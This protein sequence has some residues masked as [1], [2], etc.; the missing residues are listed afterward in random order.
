MPIVLPIPAF[1]DNY[2]W[3]IIK[4]QQAIIVDP[5]DAKPVIQA[6][7]QHQIKLSAILI[8]HWHG[9]HTNGIKELL[10]TYPEAAVIGPQHA[11]IPATQIVQDNQSLTVAGINF[12]VLAVPGHTLEHVAYYQAEQEWLF[13]GDTL[14]AA[15]CGR[16]FEGSNEQMLTSLQRLAALPES[17]KIFCAHEYTLSN[18]AFALAVEPHNPAIKQ[19]IQTCQKLRDKNH[20]T[21]PSTLKEEFASNPFLR[22]SEADVIAAAQQQGAQNHQAVSIFTA[23]REWKNNY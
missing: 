9:D 6:L 17:T 14:F 11:K 21:L 12:N 16:V 2:I 7:K 5:G 13:S 1:D 4:Q 20:P 10:Q 22:L 23:L 18:L 3:L 15:G 19:R 8:T